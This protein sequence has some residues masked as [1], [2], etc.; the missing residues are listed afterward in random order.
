MKKS[1]NGD[2]AKRRLVTARV[3]FFILLLPLF[4]GMILTG[5]YHGEIADLAADP[6]DEGASDT[7]QDSPVNPFRLP[8]P[9]EMSIVKNV[10]PGLMLREG[11]TIEN[12]SFTEYYYKKTNIKFK[13]DWYASDDNYTQKLHLAVESN[14]LPDAMIV[15]E[16]MFRQLAEYDQIE[17]LSNVYNKYASTLLKEIYSSSGE[18]VLEN[19]T[20]NGRLMALPNISIHADSISMLWVRQ[21]WLNRLNL[22]PPQTMEDVIAIAKAFVEDDP[23]GNGLKDTVGLSGNKTNL[24]ALAGIFNFTGIFAAHNAYP[25]L[26]MQDDNGRI[27]YGSTQPETKHALSTIRSMYASGLIDPDFPYRT[28]PLDLLVAGRSGMFFGPWF[29]PWNIVEAVKED[30]A[31]DWRP[32]L[33][34]DADGHYNTE[35]MPVS[36]YYLVVRKGFAHPE[37]VIVYANQLLSDSR[38]PDEEYNKLD[39]AMIITLSPLYLT[40]DYA[41]AV[42]RKYK[43]L[44]QVLEGKASPYS[45]S[46]EM[47][48]HYNRWL[49]REQRSEMNVS[50]WAAPH[51]YLYGGEIVTQ[52]MDREVYN[53]FTSMTPTMEQ[54]W[55]TLFKF[56]N[57]TFYKIVLGEIPVD[58]FDDFVKDWY[59]Q[60]GR[61]II[62]EIEEQLGNR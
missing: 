13:V 8:Y 21:D 34:A 35:R 55:D 47:M 19:A 12:N 26:W 49:R 25:G 5:C 60:G 11:E 37:A 52:Q 51:A 29:A 22:A 41:D 53:Q 30:P 4:S 7:T 40:I 61:T 6:V 27:V 24:Y 9:V 48:G 38:L 33:I 18:G 2:S 58:S 46:P 17:D 36:S 1:G 56:E 39:P 20:I 15:D 42:S 45:L 32:Y 59:D 57:E 23:D 16:P 62:A 14:V 50:D 3:M 28:E 54:K 31:A 44:V 43:E 10:P